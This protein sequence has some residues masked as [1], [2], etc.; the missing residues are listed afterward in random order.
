MILLGAFIEGK[1][2]RRREKQT[3]GLVFSSIVLLQ[4]IVEV[5]GPICNQRVC[6]SQR[7]LLLLTDGWRVDVATWGR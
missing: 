1:E 6:L 4:V 5:C 3:F 7:R 2:R